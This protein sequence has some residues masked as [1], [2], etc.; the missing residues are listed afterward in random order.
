MTADQ[1]INGDLVNEFEVG[2]DD[3]NVRQWY[4][5]TDQAKNKKNQTDECGIAARGV[6]FQVVVS[7]Q[8]A[9]SIYSKTLTTPATPSMVAAFSVASSPSA[10]VT[11]PIR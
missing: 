4:E 10:C 5:R 8:G 7:G 6:G 11:K 3:L 1:Q 9:A 2:A